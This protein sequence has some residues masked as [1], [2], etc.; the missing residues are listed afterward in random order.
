MPMAALDLMWPN[1]AHSHYL[2]RPIL[3]DAHQDV[4]L[5]AGRELHVPEESRSFSLTMAVS[6]AIG[7]SFSRRRRP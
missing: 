6:A 1:I 3:P 2:S 7:L 4:A 5:A